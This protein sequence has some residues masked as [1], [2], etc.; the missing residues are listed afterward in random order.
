MISLMA[1]IMGQAVNHLII[2]LPKILEKENE[3]RHFA[4]ALKQKPKLDYI[5]T[6]IHL[7]VFNL[8]I[9][10]MGAS[11]Q[12]YLYLVAIPILIVVFVIDWKHQLIPDT[13]QIALVMVGIINILINYNAALAYLFGALAG[14]GI[15]LAIGI[16][17]KLAYKKEGMGF[18]DV[19]IMFALGL[20]FGLKNILTIS[21]L[22]FFIAA[23]ISIVLILF[24][25][26]KLDEYIPF[27]PFIVIS[28]T[29]VMLFGSEMF[30]NIYISSC[31]YI[32]LKFTD[33]LF[34]LMY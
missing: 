8:S 12:T 16:L 28:S 23:A 19:K 15:F 7:I 20:L 9:Y 3:I 32:G 34:K 29:L 22:S 13:M 2:T 14:G 26:K 4:S 18:G 31:T 27:G 11:V 6:A 1:L 5:Y 21:I 30:F 24:K 10:I 17:G 33:L 25:R